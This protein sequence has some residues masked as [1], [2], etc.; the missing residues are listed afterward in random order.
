[1]VLNNLILKPIHLSNKDIDDITNYCVNL[2]Y[3]FDL[4]PIE[5]GGKYPMIRKPNSIRKGFI[6]REHNTLYWVYGSKR[7][8]ISFYLELQQ[9]YMKFN[10]ITFTANNVILKFISGITDFEFLNNYK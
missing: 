9:K 10:S 4:T 3:I 8:D 6:Q 1:M 7:E 5:F 2:G